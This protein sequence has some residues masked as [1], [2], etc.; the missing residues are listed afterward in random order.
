MIERRIDYFEALESIF[1][2]ESH[3]PR[4]KTIRNIMLFESVYIYG[5]RQVDL[6]EKFNLSR[7]KVSEISAKY[8]KK[9][10]E[11]NAEVPFS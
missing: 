10:H 3:R 9:F 2:K 1:T 8:L 7:T 4:A 5:M 11:M 6:M